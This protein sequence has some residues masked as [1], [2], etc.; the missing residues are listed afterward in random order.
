MGRIIHRSHIQERVGIEVESKHK[1]QTTVSGVE[2]EECY[3]RRLVATLDGVP[4]AII[5]SDDLKRNKRAAGRH[6][7]LGDLENLP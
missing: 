2:F 7:D 3:T 5:S 1:N 6:K 4:V